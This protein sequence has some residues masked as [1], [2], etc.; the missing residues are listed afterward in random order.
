MLERGLGLRQGSLPRLRGQRALRLRRCFARPPA[1][2]RARTVDVCIW[3][4]YSST[5]KASQ[6]PHMPSTFGRFLALHTVASSLVSGAMTQLL[7]GSRAFNGFPTVTLSLGKACGYRFLRIRSNACSQVAPF[8]K[9]EKFFWNSIVHF[10][11][12]SSIV[13]HEREKTREREGGALSD[14][15]RGKFWFHLATMTRC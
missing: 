3:F 7:K 14:L 15:G 10:Y 2:A 1:L 8:C 12:S 9:M 5:R 6:V 4:W 13:L 11:K